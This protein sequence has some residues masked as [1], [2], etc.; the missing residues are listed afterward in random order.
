M[1]LVCCVI[2]EQESRC[3][4]VVEVQGPLKPSASASVMEMLLLNIYATILPAA[5][6]L[7]S[8]DT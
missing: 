2:A 3:L 8:H 4:V 7:D 6:S 1:H 5:T